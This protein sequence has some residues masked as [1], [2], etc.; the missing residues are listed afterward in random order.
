MSLAASYVLHDQ[1]PEDV[2]DMHRAA[3]GIAGCEPNATY[4]AEGK[5]SA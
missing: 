5:L 2:E 1:R 3:M 4:F